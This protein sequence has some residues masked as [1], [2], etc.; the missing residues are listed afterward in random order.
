[1]SAKFKVQ[2]VLAPCGSRGG[3]ALKAGGRS[4]IGVIVATSNISAVFATALLAPYIT[5]FAVRKPA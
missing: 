5:R 4:Q 1:M 3:I 2:R